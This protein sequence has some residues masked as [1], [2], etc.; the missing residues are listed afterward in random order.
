MNRAFTVT[1]RAGGAIVQ[2]PVPPFKWWRGLRERKVLED[3]FIER[4]K[5]RRAANGSDLL[6]VL[7]QTE[8]DEGNSLPKRMSV[9][10]PSDAVAQFDAVIA[11]KHLLYTLALGHHR[12]AGRQ[13][14]E[15]F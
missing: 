5:A 9:G 7:C 14:V 2:Y 1:T 3:H 11:I 13:S 10:A 8:D 12:G 6:T 15:Q 4:V